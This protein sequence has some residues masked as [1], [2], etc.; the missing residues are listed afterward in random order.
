VV[1]IAQRSAIDAFYT[2]TDGFFDKAIRG[3]VRNAVGQL[4]GVDADK[5]D[6]VVSSV[7][8][9][10]SEFSNNRYRSPMDVTVGSL[11]IS[12]LGKFAEF[13]LHLQAFRSATDDGEATVGG[14][15]ESLVITPEHGVRWRNRL[16]DEIHGIEDSSHAFE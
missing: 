12:N 8:D 6:E 13:L 4:D 11:G 1:P 3:A 7:Q 9:E 16:S 2:G 10:L 14:H 15:I 5:V